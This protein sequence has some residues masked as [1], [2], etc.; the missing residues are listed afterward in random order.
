MKWLRDLW[1]SRHQPATKTDFVLI[2]G[3]AGLVMLVFLAI[4]A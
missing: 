3:F 2:W 4:A 1:A